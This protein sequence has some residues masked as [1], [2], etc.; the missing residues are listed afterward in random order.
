[1]GS[2]L[3]HPRAVFL[4]GRMRRPSLLLLTLALS[5][6]VQLDASVVGAR[7]AAALS[8]TSVVR[9]GVKP[10]W[11]AV[12]PTRA[13]AYVT[14]T[15]DGTLSVVDLTTNV[16][17][18]EIPVGHAPAIVAL[19]PALGRGYVSDFEDH[20]LTVVDL[21][22]NTVASVLKLG[23]LGIAVDTIAH[24]V[25]ASGGSDIVVLD[26]ASTDV[27]LR[28]PAPKGAILWGVAVD[29]TQGTVFATDLLSPRVVAFD[30]RG[31]AVGSIA[32]PAPGRFAIGIDPTS[33][34]LKVATYV[35][36][37]AQLVVIETRTLRVV[38]RTAIEPLPFALT[39]GKKPG[40]AYATSLSG[41]AVTSV[42]AAGTVTAAQ[43]ERGPVFGLAAFQGRLLLLDH[44]TDAASQRGRLLIIDPPAGSAY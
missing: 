16:V 36:S 31:V 4:T 39:F 33:G 37:G 9:V 43:A 2:V 13:R 1:M 7:P 19:D 20:T 26:G 17:I 3:V 41:A 23:G 25:Y 29:P 10:T 14:N 44:V 32:L 22:A 40:V 12:D 8:P 15:G 18:A 21:A 34:T 27:L 5:L 28:I 30:S 6:I 11:I 35:D 24:R 42:G 38:S